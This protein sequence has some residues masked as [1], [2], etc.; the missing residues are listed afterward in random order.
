[1]TVLGVET[2]TTVCAVALLRGADIVSEES[3]DEANVHAEKVLTL[4]DSVLK[5]AACPA[6]SIDAV[7]VSIG[8]GSFTGLRIGLST[9][10]G[11]ACGLGKPLV[12]VPTLQAL[13]QRLV[14][15]GEVRD[16]ETVLAL[17]DARRDEVYCQSFRPAGGKAVPLWEARDLSVADLIT[18]LDGLEVVAAGDGWTKLFAAVQQNGVRARIRCAGGEL[19]KCSASSVALLGAEFLQEGRRSDARSLEPLYIK[20]FYFKSKKVE[21]PA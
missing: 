13:A 6:Q 15:A 7:A 14:D 18:Q 19:S 12:A 10:K 2:A 3:I 16:R 5:A 4:V 17:L 9:A 20:D 1:M 21:I 11:L 8:P